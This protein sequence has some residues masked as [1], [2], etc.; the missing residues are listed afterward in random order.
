MIDDGS[1][2]LF[3]GFWPFMRRFFLLFLPLWVYLLCW[4]AGLNVLV[5]AII[6]GFSVSTVA[7]FEKIR[8]KSESQ[9]SDVDNVIK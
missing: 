7:I 2:D 8:I 1:E 3:G 9:T 6:A 4:S 5:S